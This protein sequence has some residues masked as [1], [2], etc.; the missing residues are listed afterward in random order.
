M[1]IKTKPLKQSKGKLHLI[2]NPQTDKL[3]KYLT[4][5][6]ALL[7]V[8]DNL[9]LYFKDGNNSSSNQN[10]SSNNKK[11]S[12]KKESKENKEESSKKGSQK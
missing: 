12:D 5:E 9:S 10:N 3:Q 4:A 2:L 7:G 1:N 8:I 6:A 11:D